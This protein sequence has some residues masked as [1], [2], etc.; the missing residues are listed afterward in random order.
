MATTPNSKLPYPV[1]T[2]APDGPGAILALAS[3]LDMAYLPLT[4]GPSYAQVGGTMFEVVRISKLV[5]VSFVVAR[6]SGAVTGND[7]L[8]TLPGGSTPAGQ[9]IVTGAQSVGQS[10]T[11]MTLFVGSDGAV[12]VTA[13]TSSGTQVAGSFSF[14]TGP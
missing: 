8:V 13:P 6:T 1:A 14:R 11:P 9:I 3:A 4:L 5:L 12:R 7:L 2:D 10:W